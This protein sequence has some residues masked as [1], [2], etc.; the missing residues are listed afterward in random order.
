MLV[1]QEDYRSPSFCGNS[2]LEEGE[3]CDCGLEPH[4]CRDPCCYPGLL[5]AAQRAGNLSARPCHTNTSPH[6]TQPWLSPVMFGLVW[7]WTF[8]LSLVFLLVLLLGLDWRNNKQLYLH[9]AEYQPVNT[10]S[11]ASQSPHSQSP[12]SHSSRSTTS[13]TATRNNRFVALI[14]AFYVYLSSSPFLTDLR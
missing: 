13:A 14:Y 8:I 4:H 5:T 12:H 11:G 6:C 10:S 1:L 3:E 9:L 2:V 7:P